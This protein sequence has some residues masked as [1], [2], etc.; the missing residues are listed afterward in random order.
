GVGFAIGPAQI[1]ALIEPRAYTFCEERGFVDS[2][3][4]RRLLP[5]ERNPD[6]LRVTRNVTDYRV[7]QNRVVDRSLDVE[8]VERSIGRRVPR[9]RVVE[10]DSVGAARRGHVRGDTV[11]V[12]QPRVHAR[13]DV[14]P[15]RGKALRR[16]APEDGVT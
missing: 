5:I 15:P 16:G 7:T 3:L 1:A 12:F 6:F 9:Q 8:R 10:V 13:S 14:A 2:G 4:H 11:A